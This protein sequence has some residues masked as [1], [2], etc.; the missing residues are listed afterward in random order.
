MFL[1]TSEFNLLPPG[2][3]SSIKGTSTCTELHTVR[4]GSLPPPHFSPSIPLAEVNP[5]LM[6]EI[7]D[8]MDLFSTAN[9]GRGANNFGGDRVCPV[10]FLAE[11][12]WVNI[13]TSFIICVLIVYQ[14]AQTDSFCLPW[15]NP[16]IAGALPGSFGREHVN[17]LTGLSSKCLIRSEKNDLFSTSGP[18][19]DP[20]SVLYDSRAAFSP[21]PENLTTWC[22]AARAFSVDKQNPSRTP[23]PAVMPYLLKGAGEH[24]YPQG[25]EAR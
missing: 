12:S 25:G 17:S 20:D 5:G 7:K 18:I 19:K 11:Q 8:E 15:L 22:T 9:T 14:A 13:S 3:S 10:A 24:L 21:K 4:S 23:C 6:K 2:G 16:S 1:Y